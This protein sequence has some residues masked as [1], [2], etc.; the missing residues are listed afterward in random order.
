VR[1]STPIIIIRGRPFEYEVNFLELASKTLEWMDVKA[2]VVGGDENWKGN[3]TLSWHEQCLEL[4]I[5]IFFSKINS[6]QYPYHDYLEKTCTRYRAC[7]RKS[8]NSM[9]RI[10]NSTRLT[11]IYIYIYIYNLNTLKNKI[12]RAKHRLA[13]WAC[14]RKST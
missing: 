1:F 11:I 5:S 9:I 4:R 7:E 2:Y 8:I 3:K 6:M 10:I 14:E 13:P 12:K